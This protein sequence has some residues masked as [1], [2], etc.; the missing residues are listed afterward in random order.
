MNLVLPEIVSVGIYHSKVAE[1]SRKI[2]KN[3]KTTMF[4][5]EMPLEEGGVSYINQEEMPIRPGL[6]ICA[7]P[8][9]MRHTKFPFKC[10]Y[11]HMIV[12]EGILYDE[13]M[14]MQNYIETNEAERCFAILEKLSSYTVESVDYDMI[15]MQSLVLELISFL[16]QTEKK[17]TYC[18]QIKSNHYASIEQAMRYIDEHFDSDLSLNVIAEQVGF[19][20][21]HFRALA[22]RQHLRDSSLDGILP[23]ITVSRQLRPL[24]INFA[25]LFRTKPSQ[26]RRF[27]RAGEP[28]DA[29]Q[30]R[31]RFL[32]LR[33]VLIRDQ[34]IL[35]TVFIE[36][37]SHP[38]VVGRR[39]ADHPRAVGNGG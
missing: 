10:L 3:R 32:F 7:K 30:S 19:S 2:S 15:R 16:I 34:V 29:P 26:F 5:I 11:I 31:R 38:G 6:I 37:A 23:G 1:K 24:K 20:P 21:V 9:Q 8:G 22:A 39:R 33:T 28:Q 36:Q 27:L 4:E 13:L 25:Q 12:R 17:R 18:E 35:H 14:Q